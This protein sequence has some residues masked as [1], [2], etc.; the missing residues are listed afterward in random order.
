[1]N[2]LHLD[3]QHSTMVG[4]QNQQT[5]MHVMWSIPH[6]GGWKKYVEGLDIAICIEILISQGRRFHESAGLEPGTHAWLVKQSGAVPK[7]LF[8]LKTIKTWLYSYMYGQIGRYVMLIKNIYVMLPNNIMKS[9]M[10]K[11]TKGNKMNTS[12]YCRIY[13]QIVRNLLYWQKILWEN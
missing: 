5:L 6:R 13:T 8:S 3:H 9:P 12:L 2:I 10:L 11:V 1:M 7:R 4:Q